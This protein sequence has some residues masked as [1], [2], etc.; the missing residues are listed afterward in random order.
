MRRQAT[1][2]AVVRRLLWDVGENLQVAASAVPRVSPWS[3]GAVVSAWQW[4]AGGTMVVVVAVRRLV[5]AVAEGKRMPAGKSSPGRQLVS[6]HRLGRCRLCGRLSH[7][8]STRS[9]LGIYIESDSVMPNASYHASICGS[10]P[11]TLHSPRAWGS[12]IVATRIC[13]SRML[14]AHRLA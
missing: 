12:V 3:G 11:L 13:S 1:L 6:G 4:V 5:R 2:Q 9:A 7:Q 14:A 8:T 10:A